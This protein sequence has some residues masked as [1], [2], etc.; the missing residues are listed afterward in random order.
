MNQSLASKW[1]IGAALFYFVS[2]A[3]LF[4]QL[5]RASPPPAFYP[6]SGVGI[7][8][9]NGYLH[10]YGRRLDCQFDK[11]QP[12]P[13]EC[14]VT[15]AGK[16]LKIQVSRSSTVSD[17]PYALD[18]A[19]TFNGEPLPCHN[20]LRHSGRIP[21]T[22]IFL[23]APLDLSATEMEQLQQRFW[24]ENLPE[25]PYQQARWIISLFSMGFAIVGFHGLF[26]R[27]WPAITR[28]VALALVGVSAYLVAF[29]TLFVLTTHLWD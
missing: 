14:S 15:L 16:L 25:Y 1:V 28:N 5:F 17:Q 29:A 11:N 2:L 24:L 9:E 20:D 19:A 21:P 4:L 8:D 7:Q 18:C 26:P 6:V 22:H 10:F 3:I 13:A 12:Y 27:H 23:D